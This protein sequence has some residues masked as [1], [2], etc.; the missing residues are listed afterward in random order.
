MFVTDRAQVDRII[1]KRKSQMILIDPI[2]FIFFEG[3]NNKSNEIRVEIYFR[4]FLRIKI[5]KRKCFLNKKKQEMGRKR[6]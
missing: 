1:F 3:I 6:K 5:G 2:L 4:P